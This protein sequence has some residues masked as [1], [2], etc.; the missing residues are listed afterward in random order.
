MDI[1]HFECRK[2]VKKLGNKPFLINPLIFFL[3]CEE[4]SYPLQNVVCIGAVVMFLHNFLV[5][6]VV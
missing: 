1:L 2:N 5:E 3:W 4:A 6:Y